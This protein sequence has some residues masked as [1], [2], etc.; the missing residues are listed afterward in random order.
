MLCLDAT[1]SCCEPQ[2]VRALPLRFEPPRALLLDE[3]SSL[4]AFLQLE[5]SFSSAEAATSSGIPDFDGGGGADHPPGGDAFSFAGTTGTAARPL[6]FRLRSRQNRP[7]H[8]PGPWFQQSIVRGH[9]PHRM[10]DSGLSVP[11][12][13][14]L[15]GVRHLHEDLRGR[16]AFAE[17]PDVSAGLCRHL[18]DRS[19]QFWRSS[20]EMVGMGLGILPLCYLFPCRAYL[21]NMARDS[22]T[23][24]DLSDHPES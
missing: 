4:A 15:Q 12:G 14:S 17:C 3:P 5:P 22:T 21:G 1:S 7:L 18:P 20:R 24:P 16:F 19:Y 2:A 11:G 6:A 9:R 13:G 23:V 8:R 10:D